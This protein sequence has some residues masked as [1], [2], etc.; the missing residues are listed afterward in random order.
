MNRQV[1]VRKSRDPVLWSVYMDPE[2]GL[3]LDFQ[4]PDL[5]L[6]RIWAGAVPPE[7]LSSNYAAT[8][9][10]TAAHSAGYACV[11]GEVF[12]R[13]P[14]QKERERIV[15]DEGVCLDPEDYTIEERL[16]FDIRSDAR[17]HAT[18][19]SLR[20]AVIAL[21]DIW[22]PEKIY[23]PKNNTRFHRF[24]QMTEGLFNYDPRYGDHYFRETMPTFVGRNWLCD[25]VLMV[26]QE[27]REYNLHLVDA[28][29]AQDKLQAYSDL[30]IFW[31]E[32]LPTS[33][34]CIGMVLAE[35]QMYD[36]TFQ[37]REMEIGDGYAI[38]DPRQTQAL[39]K[40]V[41]DDVDVMAWWAGETQGEAWEDDDDDPYAYQGQ[42]EES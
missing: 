31:E 18:L 20:R 26:D 41:K 3:D 5:K 40:G 13:D 14:M 38:E 10:V 16:R 28:L 6:S 17:Q 35:M 30:K 42:D 1:K 15:L 27:E 8:G 4:E 33:Y 37:I 2:E 29:L 24:I 7:A 36:M 11:I 23:T 34:R 9:T 12:D 22:L 32:K 21:K 25:G 39:L 19:A